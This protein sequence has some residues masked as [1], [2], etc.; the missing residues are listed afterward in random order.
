MQVIP[1]GRSAFV[2]WEHLI[3]T[4]AALKAHAETKDLVALISAFIDEFDNVLTSDLQTR[5]KVISAKALT[6]VADSDLDDGIR[7]TQASA[8]YEVK[9]NRSS[10]IYT[11]LF[12]TDINSTTRYAL[13]RQLKVAEELRT[14]LELQIIP[15]ILR[16]KHTAALDEVIASGH[17]ALRNKK[18]ARFER[19]NQKMTMDEWKDNVNSVRL[20]VYSM[21]LQIASKTNRKASWANT[22][23]ARVTRKRKLSEGS[24]S[25]DLFEE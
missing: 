19:A 3:F 12:G 17:E 23:F 8:L 2:F 1:G 7:S 15:E 9:Q 18:E 4:E 20:S 13:E 16:E 24:N 5:R 6:N 21:L 25:V 22:F 14:S 11:V 10:D